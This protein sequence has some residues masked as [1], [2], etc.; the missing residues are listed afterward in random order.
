MGY[1]HVYNDSGRKIKVKITSDTNKNGSVRF[2]DLNAFSSD[3]WGR[4]GPEVVFV[5]VEGSDV[6]H[7]LP[8]IPEKTTVFRLPDLQFGLS[9]LQ[10]G[11]SPQWGPYPPQFG[12][13]GQQFGPSAPQSA[14]CPPQFGPWGQQF[15]QP[16]V[17]SLPLPQS[18]PFGSGHHFVDSLS[19]LE[20]NSH[21]TLFTAG[22]ENV[23]TVEG[24]SVRLRA[25]ASGQRT[26]IFKCVQNELGYLGLVS[27]ETG[28]YLGRSGDRELVS[29][30][31]H[32][33]GWEY[34]S[35]ERVD[36]GKY[37]VWWSARQ[38]LL[39]KEVSDPRGNYLGPSS[40][41]FCSDAYTAIAILKVTI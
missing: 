33:Q 24:D 22:T 10:F 20:V 36:V 5:V 41:D 1:I 37:R 29:S 34:F 40:G 19:P 4:E 12:P 27:V 31:P 7:T 16:A 30:A 13:W 18:D 8:G 35:L 25:H 11:P 38:T 39:L 14:P 28:K 23:L 26:Q 3:H 15:G 32:H 21:Y 9:S 17:R 2:F 6:I